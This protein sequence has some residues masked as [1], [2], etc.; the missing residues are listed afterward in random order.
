MND[1]NDLFDPT[2]W[3]RAGR[4][5]RYLQFHRHI[6]A[7][8]QAGTLAAEDQLPAERDMAERAS[9]S[10]VTVR[11]AVAQLVSDGLI[12]QRQGA[13]SF[14]R[15]TAPRLQQSLSSLISFT[16]N[17]SAR[18][19]TSSSEVLSA[20]LYLP[21]QTEMLTLGL[22]SHQKAARVQRLRSAGGI[23]M[24]IEVSSLP[25]DILPNPD[26]VQTSL[27]AVLRKTGLA[28]T[29][30]IQRVTAVNASDTDAEM[31]QLPHGT[32]VLK[33]ERTA[34]LAT[35]RPIEFTSGMY[36]SDLYDFVSELRQE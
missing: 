1:P 23:P 2:H 27:Y 34:F 18:G 12:E 33:I 3:L 8:I 14:V 13:G 5:P 29:R 20:G 31:L 7:A 9:I 19:M 10:R 22:G 11:K 4:G 35:G 16:E 17:M 32:A 36:R 24:A 21:S 30:A 15:S 25:D 26:L 6:S 28:P